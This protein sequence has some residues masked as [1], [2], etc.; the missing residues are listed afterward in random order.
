MPPLEE[1]AIF[2]AFLLNQ[3]SNHLRKNKT[4]LHHCGKQ[5]HLLW[6][7]GSCKKS[8]PLPLP[9]LVVGFFRIIQKEKTDDL[10]VA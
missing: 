1:T 7:R 9:L 3:Y 4:L 8:T 10:R 6:L 5:V 2:A